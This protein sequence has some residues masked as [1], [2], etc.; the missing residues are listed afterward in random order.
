MIKKIYNLA[1]EVFCKLKLCFTGNFISRVNKSIKLKGGCVIYETDVRFSEIGFGSYTGPGVTILGGVTAGDGAVIG[2]GAV[3][4][5]DVLPYSVVP[6]VPA[7]IIKFRF[8]EHTI[9]KTMKIKW[10]DWN[11]DLISKSSFLFDDVQRFI[12]ACSRED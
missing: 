6:G 5:K 7:K 9:E 8:N 3:V 2:T 11:I 12:D 1:N 4:T 10:L